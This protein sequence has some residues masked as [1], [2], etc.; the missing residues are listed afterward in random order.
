MRRRIR[1]ELVRS[2]R[3][4]PGKDGNRIETGCE[5]RERARARARRVAFFPFLFPFLIFPPLA[6][7]TS[8][9]LAPRWRS[10]QRRDGRADT[11]VGWARILFLLV[12]FYCRLRN[13][14]N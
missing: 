2:S 9:S 13:A 3:A 4:S 14:I 5:R 7:L 12:A 8:S 6:S 11:R 10:V 1:D